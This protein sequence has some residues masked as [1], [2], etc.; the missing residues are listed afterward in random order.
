MAK[1]RYKHVR[2]QRE[3]KGARL[4]LPTLTALLE[5]STL[6]PDRPGRNHYGYQLLTCEH[7]S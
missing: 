1:F 4:I 2:A 3:G 6:P 7:E 5:Q